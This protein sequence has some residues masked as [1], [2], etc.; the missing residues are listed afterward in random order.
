MPSVESDQE[1]YFNISIG[2]NE[3]D[4]PDGPNVRNGSTT[5]VEPVNRDFRSPFNS[6]HSSVRRLL[7]LRAMSGHSQQL[8][9][10]NPADQ[11]SGRLQRQ[12]LHKQQIK[13]MRAGAP[14]NRLAQRRLN[15]RNRNALRALSSLGQAGEKTWHRSRT[16]ACHLA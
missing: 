9:D 15:P 14:A 3:D 11:P 1:L 13:P 4:V 6:R 16:E 7:Q 8:V 2:R 10:I 5:E 12:H